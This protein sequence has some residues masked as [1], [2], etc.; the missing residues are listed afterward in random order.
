MCP[1]VAVVGSGPAADAAV[2]TLHQYAE[3]ERDEDDPSVVVTRP[4]LAEFDDADLVV[5][6]DRVGASAF[7]DANRSAI[8]F[9]TPWI[10]VEL[11]GIGGVPVT[12]AAVTGFDPDGACYDCLADRVAANVDEET[13]PVGAVDAEKQYVAGAIA[14]EA[15]VTVVRGDSDGAVLGRVTE[16]PH[17]KR[18]LLPVPG[19]HCGGDRDM[20]VRRD[21]EAV[22]VEEA[23]GRAE[24]G[25]DDRVGI[26]TQVGEVES[27]PA[28][29]YLANLSDT[30]GFSDATAPRQAAGVA[31]DWDAAFMKALGESYERYAAGVYRSADAQ[32][33]PA[34]E[35]DSCVP[36]SS[37]VTP[38]EPSWDA[39]TE[40]EWVPAT[41]LATDGSTQVPADLVFHP[42]RNRDVR[43]PLTTGLGLGSSSVGA[44]LSG[45]YEVV[46]RDAS[47]IAWYSTYDPLGLAVED[48]E[49][50][51]LAARAG[52]EGLDVTTLLLTQDVDVPV[53]AVAVHRDEWPKLALGSSAHLDPEEAA[54]GA[55]EEAVQNWME[56][57]RMGPERA[58]EAG[59]AIGEYADLPD[60]G[61]ELIDVDQGVPAAS[62]GPADVPEGRAHLDA[63]V[64]R[65]SDAG[66][67]P[68]AT[69]T[70]TRDLESIDFEAVRVLVPG[71]QPLFLGDS[72]FG[73]RARTVP[74]DL[75]FEFTPDRPHH[76]FP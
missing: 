32:T 15:A 14:G 72:F 47:M 66:L 42:P 61:R 59:G 52:A 16:I 3:R 29:Y 2:A 26:T 19:C 75:G 33:A 20:T 69:R 70:T 62:V 24:R 65:I 35:L 68:Y 4:G 76:P 49:F 22:S 27:Y 37:F 17:A 40:T 28:P 51:T 60:A 44:M 53:I 41:N 45:L 71:A 6:V 36:P 64:D 25:L 63:L 56:L 57:R 39:G 34:T 48:E 74:A 10:A 8:E 73:E 7:A 5:V 31:V 38:E 46:E 18:R 43:P 58:A 9:A 55:L 13:D 21:Y 54:R 12:T 50:Q 23:L 11:G 30:S 67:T 1:A